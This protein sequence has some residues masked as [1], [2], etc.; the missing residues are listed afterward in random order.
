MTGRA[1][2]IMPPEWAPHAGTILSWPHNVDEWGDAHAA[3]EQAFVELATRLSRVETVHVNVPDDAWV[4]RVGDALDGAGAR[5]AAVQLH[6]IRTD[7]VWA[8]D[9]GPSVV[10]EPGAP[11][12]GPL[13]IDWVFDAW[14]GKYPHADDAAVPARLAPRLGARRAAVDVVM[15]GGAF[16]VNGRGD[17]LTTESAALHPNRGD[18]TRADLE[19]AF[20]E[21]LGVR[22]VC[23]LGAGLAGDDTDG[24]V[25]DLARFVDD[26][27]IACVVSDDPGDEDHDAL[28]ENLERLRTF[29]GV[30]ERR[31]DIVALPQPRP[32]VRDGE[33]LPASYA[34]FY[35]ANG[36]VL[37][38]VFDQPTDAV[39]IERLA[40]AM[41]DRR[42]VGID[43]RGLV[44]QY[45][46]L[47]C[48]TQQLPAALSHVTTL[49]G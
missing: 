34:N 39:A 6:L 49:R 8:R 23:W 16:D 47:H 22:R 37:V 26:D 28:A 19:A 4:Q 40:A 5:R 25:D 45:G 9:H 33:R 2:R 13:W 14:G 42:V 46:A 10:F 31:F 15:E 11:D 44:T 30:G 48:V 21:H 20:G 18:R 7:D 38:P 27:T 43:A 35:V 12:A 41:P 1:Q 3:A 29:V 17:L 32:V 24:H 36:L